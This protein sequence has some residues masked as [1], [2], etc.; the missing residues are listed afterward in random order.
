MPD[1]KGGVFF[2]KKKEVRNIRA[3]FSMGTQICAGSHIFSNPSVRAL[4]ICA[5]SSTGGFVVSDGDY[6]SWLGSVE[7][8]FLGGELRPNADSEISTDSWL[9]SAPLPPSWGSGSVSIP[10]SSSG[11][12]L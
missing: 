10:F 7:A 2:L 5:G 11:T 3:L 1:G 9:P 4:A 6:I 8:G 12:E